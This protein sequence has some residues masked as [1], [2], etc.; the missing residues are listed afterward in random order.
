MDAEQQR[1]IQENLAYNRDRWG[2]RENWERLDGFGYNWSNMHERPGY[3]SV[4]KMATDFLIPWSNGRYD[5]NILEVAPG[6]GRFTAELLRIAKSLSIVD[7]NAACIELCRERFR[8][9][10]NVDYFVNDGMSVAMVPDSS[11]DLVASW[12]SFV[13]I[14]P[15]IIR[16]YLIGFA[17][18]LR[19]GG[20]V[21]LHHSATGERKEGHR[22]AMTDLR[23]R[24]FAK[25]LNYQVLAQYYLAQGGDCISVLRKG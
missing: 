1:K 25:E 8:Y 3:T 21:W 11:F 16:S 5:L 22:T 6:A 17:T 13:H 9:Y 19:E 4:S 2:Q 18:K 10:S 12:D 24:E 15:E 7:M 23:M 20:T 14:E